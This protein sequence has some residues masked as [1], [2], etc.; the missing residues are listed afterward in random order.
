MRIGLSY[1]LREAVPTSRSGAEDALEEYDSLET[2]EAIG[3]A[4]ESHGHSVVWLGGG[5]E[6]LVT[7]LREDVD[8]V[9]NISEGLG[10]HRSREAQVPSVLE[11]LDIPYTGSDPVC[12]GMCL[13]KPLA[14]SIVAQHGVETPRW[15][16]IASQDEL[17]EVARNGFPFPAFVK[18]ACEGSS[19]GIRL[20]SR[21]DDA[22]QLTSVSALALERYRQ[23]VL[24][25]EFID[26]DEVTV[27]MVGNDPPR[28]VGVMRVLPRQSGP[29]F[30]YSLEVKRDWE[31]LVDYE[32]PAQL[33]PEVMQRIV[34]S[35]VK[36]FTTLGC[37]DVARVDFRLTR[38]GVP[39]FLE[40]NPLPGLNPRTSDLPIM[41]YRMGLSYD[42]LVGAVLSSALKRY[43][44]C[45]RR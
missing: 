37:R 30:V 2:V 13:D 10:N 24:V 32:C 19:K 27:G 29:Y 8:L 28:P 35:S 20:N 23:P 33:E 38:E 9:F 15:S 11:M 41:A 44:E 34:E 17:V 1:D 18:P 16:V 21:V 5:R 40:I 4:L 25:E 12:L 31:S 43:P 14:K 22:E 26:G 45:V 36:A 39:Y 3:A 6:F 42:A 7:I